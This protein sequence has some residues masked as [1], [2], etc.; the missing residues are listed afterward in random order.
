MFAALPGIREIRSALAGGYLWILFAWL[1]LDPSLGKSNFRAG[2][3]QSAHHLG[4]EVGPVALSIG[5]TFVA[6]LIGTVFNEGRN[7]FARAYLKTRRTMGQAPESKRA[8]AL[9]EVQQQYRAQRKRW[10]GRMKAIVDRLLGGTS[11]P[12]PLSEGSQGPLEAVVLSG[13]NILGAAIVLPSVVLRGASLLFFK[14]LEVNEAV[15]IWVLRL[16]ASARIEPYKPFLSTQ[17]VEAIERYL[18]KAEQRSLR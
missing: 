3:Y 1:L 2:P 9:A 17:G 10:E 6:Y 8:E 16:L 5:A 4:Q 18:S 12:D 11:T 14:F 13:M 15:A 7:L